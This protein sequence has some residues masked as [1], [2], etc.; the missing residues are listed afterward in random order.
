MQQ[1]EHSG[2][3]GEPCPQHN[4]RIVSERAKDSEISFEEIFRVIRRRKVG[5]LVVFVLCLAFSLFFYGVQTPEYH[6]VS[7]MIINDS[8]DPSDLLE[9]VV[10]AGDNNKVV[11]KDVELLCS[12]PI[13]E[14]TV[15]A[16]YTSGR[17]DSL[18]FFGN[19]PYLSPIARTFSFL[20]PL[21]IESQSKKQGDPD[22]RFRRYAV[23]LNKR[24]KVAVAKETN[25]LKVSVASPFPDEAVF[26]TNTLCKVYKDADILRNSEKY[27]QA[28]TFIAEML[29]DQQKK[30]TQADNAM[31]RYMEQ[32]EIFEVSGNTQQLLQKLIDVD[33]QYN[34]I[35]VEYNIA[36]NNRAFLEK[37]LADTDK[38]VSER[39]TRNVNAQLGN[40]QDEIR[41]LEGQYIA[42]MQ[43]KGPEDAEVRS[44]RQQ[45]D[46]VKTR[47]E[48]LSRSK[49]AGE[50][51]Y[52][53]QAQKYSF[54]LVGEKLQSE[55]KLDEL[56]FSAR[57]FDRLK[58]Y[59]ER[60][61]L[62]LPKK[63]QEF[64]RLQRDQEVIGKTYLYLKEKLDET[65]ILQASVVGNVSIIGSAFRP[66]KPE[67]PS[68]MR[69]I[70]VGFM[71]GGLLAIVYV[72]VAEL[73]DDTIKD[74]AFFRDIGLTVLA[75]I[76]FV[77]SKGRG[78][79]SGGGS[80]L[81]HILYSAG[82]LFRE[83]FFTSFGADPRKP[84]GSAPADDAPMPAITE[85]LSSPFA[86][87]FRTL[88]TAL[89]YSRIDSP[90]R[91]I[92]VSGTAISEGKSTVCANL[93]MAFALI[94]E[95]VLV[96]DCDLRRPSLHT[97]L[98]GERQ[99]GLTDYFFGS[100]HTIS[101][102]FF[103]QTHLDN[104][105]FLS[106]GKKVPDPNEL[107]GS[108]KMLELLEVLHGKFE[109][110]LLDCPP[111]FLSDAAHLARSVDGIL[112]VSKLRHSTRKVLREIVL[113]PAVALQP[114]GVAV[115]A[116]RDFDH[117]GYGRY[118]YSRYEENS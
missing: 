14:L 97:K 30:V 17:R 108:S 104:L 49:I 40:I 89:D 86:E 112:L 18:E 59:Y 1:R 52:A 28:N 87:S 95:K 41:T 68:L 113:D 3:M 118:G 65:R 22:D 55:R 96:V 70:L 98:N 69:N 36:K 56:S 37:K 102:S 23:K 62:Q 20:F 33:A 15:K 73:V 106:A 103:Q 11:K 79:I 94:G 90:L 21:D 45:L 29:S 4:V 77:A 5:I 84:F 39:I 93:A 91:S 6:A 54:D 46:V 16:L 47:Y 31:S 72:Y 32:N 85:S 109:K 107:L 81:S 66:F 9:K 67:K 105:F 75:V 110:I 51:R 57:E 71:I 24:I 100:E 19:R 58:Q 92:L 35:L 115:V 76:P 88:R 10:G 43:Q 2:T 78:P 50:I 114:L 8:E 111:L 27:A 83:K 38:S 101:E 117:Y 99:P 44:K 74:E 42:L 48:Q 25:V 26:L 53:G 60:L 13:A 64:V 63:Q 80:R 116:S 61:L 7:V 12:M 82:K 34:S